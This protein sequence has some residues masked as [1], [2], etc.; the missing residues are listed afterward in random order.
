MTSA[1]IAPIARMPD[2]LALRIMAPEP[3]AEALKSILLSWEQAHEEAETRLATLREHIFN[4]RMCAFRIISERELWKLDIDPEYGIPFKSMYRWMQVLYPK[5][6]GLRYALEANSTQKALPKATINDLAEMKRCNAVTLAS[7]FVSDECR[8]DP[9]VIQATKTATER[10]FRA[11]L[12]K[13]HGQMIEEVETLKF[14]YPVSDSNQ[15]KAYL[16]WVA[17][18]ADL[19][20]LEDYQSALLYLSIHENQERQIEELER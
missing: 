20:E 19:P 12:N 1:S 15:V 17:Q 9:A 10:E 6:D 13:D 7:K 2:W 18:K 5:D 3:A 16:R 14:S 4:V 8:N 11:T